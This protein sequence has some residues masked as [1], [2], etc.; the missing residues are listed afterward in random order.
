MAI[1]GGGESSAVV[2]PIGRERERR[3]VDG[4]NDESEGGR[5]RLG[6]DK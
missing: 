4:G 2:V 1:G 5:W 6:L 3:E